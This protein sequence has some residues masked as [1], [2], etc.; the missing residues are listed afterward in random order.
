MKSAV[1]L[2]RCG[3]SAGVVA[4]AALGTAAAADDVVF[5]AKGYVVARPVQVSPSVA[6]KVLWLHEKFEEGQS[7]RKGDVLARLE[8]EEYKA[9]FDKTKA[10]LD[11]ARA[12]LEGLDKAATAQQRVVAKA[13][14]EEA[15]AGLRKA[16]WRLEACTVRA[17]ISGTI[18]T[19]K[20]ELGNLV[21]PTAFQLSA[22]VCEMANLSD[23]EVEL[24]LAERDLPK[25][26]AGQ[27]CAVTP[28]AFAGIAAFLKKHPGGYR[29]VVA[30]VSPVADRARGAVGVR[31]KIDKADIP[32]EEAGVYLKPDMSVIVAF[33]KGN[34]EE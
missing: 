7:F 16:R 28:E 21:N 10:A 8:D 9:D 25:V 33:R 19:K 14:V 23:L 3:L 18:L 2:S 5:E 27:R 30:R 13:D 29:A 12:R 24:F 11:R 15:E 6:G 1:S 22:S 26:S 17:P 34:G 31:L 20:T 4:L 32:T